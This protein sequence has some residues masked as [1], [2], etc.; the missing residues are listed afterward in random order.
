[1]PYK[2]Q[3]RQREANRL[4]MQKARQGNTEPEVSPEN[5]LP[6]VL[7][8][9][10]LPDIRALPDAWAHVKEFISRPARPG[11]KGNLEKLQLIAGSL[12]KRADQVWFGLGGLTMADIGQTLGTKESELMARPPR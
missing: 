1:M 10:L 5:V 4:R 11:D 7:P 9:V 8:D 6:N 3:S 2:D 12:G